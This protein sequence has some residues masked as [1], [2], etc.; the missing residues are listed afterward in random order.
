[1]RQPWLKEEKNWGT[2]MDNKKSRHTDELNAKE[3]DGLFSSAAANPPEVPGALLQRIMADA[4]SVSEARLLASVPAAQPKA[5]VFSG[6]FG[7][8]GGW[9]GLAGLAT[10]TVVGV[11]IGFS[12]PAAVDQLAQTYFTNYSDIDLAVFAPSID[13]LL[14]E[15]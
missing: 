4:H 6:L 3:L 10:A 7:A 8:I 1:M 12:P 9:P 5:G 15:G 14:Y 11:W 2:M 13:D